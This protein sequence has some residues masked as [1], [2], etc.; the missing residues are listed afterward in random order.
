MNT[1]TARHSAMT[2]RHQDPR[3]LCAACA[4]FDQ[5]ITLPMRRIPRAPLIMTAIDTETSER[6][7]YSY[8]HGML[9]KMPVEP[10]R[11]RSP[12]KNNEKP[13]FRTLLHDFVMEKMEQ[14]LHR[15]PF[16]WLCVSSLLHA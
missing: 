10:S 14:S 3:C 7:T 9:Y 16:F 4:A 1:N 2:R 8:R 12:E 6:F 11:R 13:S 5:G 15:H